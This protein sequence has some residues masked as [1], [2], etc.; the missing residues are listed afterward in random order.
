MHSYAVIWAPDGGLPVAGRLQLD[1]RSLTLHGGSR[2]AERRV[3]VPFADI[4][5]VG[6]A[7]ERIG[8]LRA[9]AVDTGGAG[10]LLVA[11]IGG[12]ALDREILERLQVAVA[13]VC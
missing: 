3:V 10:A 13:A 2:G 8:R 1:E 6:R 4:S 7:H 9:I 5:S 12:A 11:S